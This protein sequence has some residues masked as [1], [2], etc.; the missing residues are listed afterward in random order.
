MR[1]RVGNAS[2][3]QLACLAS[4]QSLVAIEVVH[5]DEGEAIVPRTTLA[6]PETGLV[7][8]GLE[9]FG[10]AGVFVQLG[11]DLG[12]LV[13]DAG[14]GPARVEALAIVGQPI[15]LA[16]FLGPRGGDFGVGDLGVGDEA[17]PDRPDPVEDA[18]GLAQS[19]L[20]N[21]PVGDPAARRI[22]RLA[23]A[24]LHA[25]LDSE[26]FLVLQEAVARLEDGKGARDGVGRV[27]AFLRTGEDRGSEGFLVER[28][29]A[30]E[31]EVE[32]GEEC[33]YGGAEAD[34]GAGAP[35]ERG[36]EEGVLPEVP[37]LLIVFE[38]E[39]LSRRHGGHLA[40][41]AAEKVR[42]SPQ[43]CGEGRLCRRTSFEAA[44]DGVA[45]GA[46]LVEFEFFGDDLCDPVRSR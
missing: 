18:L 40:V 39:L 37:P 15:G 5:D 31:D 28:D 8:E 44:N 3:A 43:S 33:Q 7:E 32:A 12:A 34:A 23:H 30:V 4:A 25:P 10:L 19:G 42:L 6:P 26:R 20:A 27:D 29:G 22:G 1:P 9:D 38:A 11:E 2:H 41:R 35:E 45:R 36:D 13:D 21:A 14:E 24:L 17:L 16:A 46:G